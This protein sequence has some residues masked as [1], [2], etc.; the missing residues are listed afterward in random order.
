MLSSKEI[1]PLMLSDIKYCGSN[2]DM[3][4]I[5]E[6]NSNSWVNYWRMSEIW[7]IRPANYDQQKQK[8]VWLLFFWLLTILNLLVSLILLSIS[9]DCRKI[10]F[11]FAFLKTKWEYIGAC[12][13]LTVIR[14]ILRVELY[15][16]FT[17]TKYS[18]HFCPFQPRCNRWEKW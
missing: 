11:Y 16:V 2:H 14:K 10:K 1:V 3:K 6:L 9:S 17:W 18:T 7:V 15:L 8:K 13:L 5:K 4:R 12:R